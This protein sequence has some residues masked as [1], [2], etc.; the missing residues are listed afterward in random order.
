MYRLLSIAVL[1]F[2]SLTALAID[3]E[4][5]L[6]DPAQDA[7]Y[8]ALI[9]EVRCLV[10]QN[11]AIS[12]SNAPLARDLRRE[13]RQK[14]EAGAGNPEIITFLTDRYGDF[15]LYRPPFKP[16]T[17]LLWAAPALFLLI[18]GFALVRTVK[19]RTEQDY[20]TDGEAHG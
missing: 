12:D 8:R 5:P 20:G 6:S 17:Y 16:T 14:I 9:K 13:I 11:Q 18:A 10:C 2:V 4:P 3:G 19:R 7:R 1:M 15:V